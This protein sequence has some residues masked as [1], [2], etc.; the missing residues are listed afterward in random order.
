MRSVISMYRLRE[1]ANKRVTQGEYGQDG[2]GRMSHSKEC[3]ERT[4]YSSLLALF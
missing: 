1:C 2:R 3:V 4:K